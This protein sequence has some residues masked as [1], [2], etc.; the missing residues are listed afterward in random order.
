MSA[1]AE[2]AMANPEKGDGTESEDEEKK[3]FVHASQYDPTPVSSLSITTVST[4]AD[5]IVG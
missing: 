3:G 5:S 4:R 2:A 1:D